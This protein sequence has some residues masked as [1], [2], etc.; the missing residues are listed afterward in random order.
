MQHVLQHCDKTPAC[1]CLKHKVREDLA[2]WKCDHES[3]HKRS[4]VK[5]SDG[6]KVVIIISIRA[7]WRVCSEVERTCRRMRVLAE[8]VQLRGGVIS[9]NITLKCGCGQRSEVEPHDH[10]AHHGRCHKTVMQ[11]YISWR[12]LHILQVRTIRPQRGGA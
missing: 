10:R 2:R 5:L 7:S 12:A 4:H 9:A 1:V 8:E 3:D 11:G 6:R